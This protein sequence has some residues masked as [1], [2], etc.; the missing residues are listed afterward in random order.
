MKQDER[1][2]LLI[3]SVTILERVE[4]RLDNGDQKFDNIIE[5]INTKCGKCGMEELKEEVTIIKTQRNTFVAAAGFVGA[6]VVL[7]IT[8]VSKFFFGGK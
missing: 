1:D 5:Q 7:I 6:G 8:N 4:K 2:T 3:Q